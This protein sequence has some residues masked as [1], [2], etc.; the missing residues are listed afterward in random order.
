MSPTQNDS[1]PDE[2]YLSTVE[3]E[4]G[5]ESM[6]MG[7]STGAEDEID[8]SR[9]NGIWER[10][11]NDI[12]KN[13][14]MVKLKD[15]DKMKSKACKT[16]IIEEEKP[17]APPDSGKQ[18]AEVIARLSHDQ[19]G[20]VLGHLPSSTV[21]SWVQSINSIQSLEVSSGVSIEKCG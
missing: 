8:V 17:P 20:V 3:E 10:R 18:L 9:D 21:Q 16:I 2:M 6:L 5:D 4:S 11:R 14:K 15:K 7:G 13:K 19:I 1:Q 12:I